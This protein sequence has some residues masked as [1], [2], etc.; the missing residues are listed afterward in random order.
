MPAGQGSPRS[1][2]PSGPAGCEDGAEAPFRAAHPTPGQWPHLLSTLMEASGPL[3]A[4]AGQ[5]RGWQRL[6]GLSN[7]RVSW[8]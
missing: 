8:L 1:T 4:R 5:K 3:R 7:S 2:Q 6:P